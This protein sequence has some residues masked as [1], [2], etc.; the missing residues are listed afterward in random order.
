MCWMFVKNN[1]LFQKELANFMWSILWK[2]QNL[3]CQTIVDFVDFYKT[4]RFLRNL[5]TITICGLQNDVL[6]EMPTV[7]LA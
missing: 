5:Q 7:V 2:T 4:E 6:G 1:N 3:F